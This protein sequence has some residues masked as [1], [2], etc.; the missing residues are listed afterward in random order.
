MFNP[1]RGLLQIHGDS[2]LLPV[3]ESVKS[4]KYEVKNKDNGNVVASGEIEKA[5]YWNYD[6]ILT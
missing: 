2:Y 6:E 4:L 3:S 1:V 5:V